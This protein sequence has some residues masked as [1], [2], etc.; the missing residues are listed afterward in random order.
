MKLWHVCPV[1][2]YPQVFDL[3]DHH[4]AVFAE[5]DEDGTRREVGRSSTQ[6]WLC[7]HCGQVMFVSEG[8]Q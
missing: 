5:I 7:R 8:D 4:G 2:N 1:T 6:G 3:A